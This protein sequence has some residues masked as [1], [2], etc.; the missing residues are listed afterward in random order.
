LGQDAIGL[1]HR[2]NDDKE[3]LGVY[4]ECDDPASL[5][6]LDNTAIRKKESGKKFPH[7]KEH[8]T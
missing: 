2:Q 8:G 5:S 3:P 1:L 4:L 6:F 7:S